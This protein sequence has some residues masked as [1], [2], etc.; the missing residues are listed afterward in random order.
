MAHRPEI[1]DSGFRIRNSG[2]NSG[3]AF[4]F[5]QQWIIYKCRTA[6]LIFLRIVWSLYK[7]DEV[8]TPS[9]ASKG[10]RNHFL[11]STI[12]EIFSSVAFYWCFARLQI[13]SRWKVMITMIDT[14]ASLLARKWVRL[15]RAS[16]KRCPQSDA[17]RGSVA[18]Q[19]QWGCF[20]FPEKIKTTSMLVVIHHL[21]Y[22]QTLMRG[23]KYRTL[24]YDEQSRVRIAATSREHATT[25]AANYH[26]SSK[27][28]HIY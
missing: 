6:I 19:T 7:T 5:T 27:Q 11:R 26:T 24:P 21:N 28:G 4:Y 12:Y 23:M 8:K 16:D 13:C 14:C 9:G 10:L 15:G 22:Y 25:T 18:M 20:N 2:F 3:Y 17:S 1:P